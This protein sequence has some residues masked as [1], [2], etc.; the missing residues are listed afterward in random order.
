MR[1]LG[2]DPGYAIK[3]ADYQKLEVLK[4][5]RNKRYNYGEFLVEGVRNINEA[6]RNGWRFS[7]LIYSEEL[8]LSELLHAG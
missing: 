7:S 5:N 6:I 4:T 1:I 8:G 2:I 3:N